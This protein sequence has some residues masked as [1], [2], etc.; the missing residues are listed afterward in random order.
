M[1][2]FSAANSFL[3]R[4]N[5]FASVLNISVYTHTPKFGGREGDESARAR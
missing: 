4:F 2:C 5:A 3:H 1:R